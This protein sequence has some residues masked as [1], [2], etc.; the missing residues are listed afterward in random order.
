MSINKKPGCWNCWYFYEPSSGD[1]MCRFNPPVWHTPP[2]DP[3]DERAAF[4]YAFYEDWCGKW[5]S[6]PFAT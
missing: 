4:P 2:E 5:E 1:G 3:E 6:K